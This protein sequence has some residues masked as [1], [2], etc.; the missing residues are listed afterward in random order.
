[1]S[2]VAGELLRFQPGTLVSFDIDGTLELGDP[3]G[4]IR[5]SF[6]AHVRQQGCLIGSASDRT[7]REQQD[8]WTALDIEPDFVSRK[9]QLGEVRLSFDRALLFHIG[10]THIDEHFAKLAGFEYIF[11]ED[12]AAILAIE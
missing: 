1:M 11:V 5:G 6:V 2:A 9:H 10:D 7:L 8:I 3:P 4:P 12:L